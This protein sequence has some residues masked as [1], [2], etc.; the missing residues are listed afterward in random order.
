MAKLSIDKT[1][2]TV[3][4]GDTLFE[5]ARNYGGGKTYQQ[6]A[7]INNI[8][9]P[10]L[11]YVGE[12]IRLVKSSVIYPDPI[13]TV[14]K[15]QFGL[16][17]DIDNVIFISWIWNKDDTTENY[18][19]RWDYYTDNK[20]WFIGNE[21]TTND[22]YS[23]YTIPSNA[24]QVRVRV[25]P[26]SKTYKKNRKYT[27]YWES[28]WAGWFTHTISNP[29][30]KP[31]TP[32]VKL[33]GLKLTATVSNIKEENVMI[34]FQVFKDDSL[35]TNEGK[36]YA[37][38]ETASFSCNVTAGSRYKVHCRSCKDGLYSDWSDYSSNLETIPSTPSGFTKCEPKT[39]SSIQLE[40][41]AISNASGYEI[42]YTTDK[43]NFE[44]SDK[45]TSVNIEKGDITSYNITVD[46]GQEYFFRIRAVNSQG[47]SGWSEIKSTIIGSLPAAPTTWS[48]TTTVV[49]GEPLTLYWVHNSKDGS[50]QTYAHLE[51]YVDGVLKID[52]DIKNT[53][54]TEEKDKTSFYE[55]KMVDDNGNPIY[56]EGSK[57][58]WRVKTAGINNA[59]GEYSIK[60]IVN[61]Y[62]PPTLELSVTNLE[63]NTFE[64]LESFPINISALAGPKTQCPIGYV[65]SVISNEIYETV[66]N[67]GNSIIINSG[68]QIYSKHF[69]ISE[70]L[71]IELS[72]GDLNL[73]NGVSYTIRCL[74]SMDSGLTAESSKDFN[75]SW[76][77]LGYEPNAEITIDDDTLSAYIKPY[78]STHSSINYKV[79]RS[80]SNYYKTEETI[81]FVY[82]TIVSEVRTT[83][84]EQVYYGTTADGDTVYYCVIN[85]SRNIEDITL[86]VYRREF[87]GNFTELS[88]GLDGSTNT[89]IT[90][91]H[92]S[93]DYARYRIVAK[94]KANGAISYY[95]VPGYP[96]ECK[97]AIIQWD[98]D[99]T[100]FD[101]LGSE[102][103]LDQPV[104]SGSM[105]KLPYNIDI[106]DKHDSDVSLIEYIGRKHPVSYYGTHL[107][108][109]ST[110]SMEIPKDDKETLYALRRLALW[111]GDVYVREP[112]G[113][114]YWANVSVSFSQKHCELTIPIT[115][116]ITRVEGGI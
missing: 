10:D 73:E 57:L 25:R 83:T 114:G 2:V 54:T 48:S 60:R 90:D 42:E 113:S 6:L 15:K 50:S 5:I 79:T 40:W 32:I 33:E 63:G 92:P 84:G 35:S 11:I 4:R 62:A 53:N 111:M 12:K 9:N 65:L 43:S 44:E 91:P 3:E 101:I 110:W 30:S 87:D 68:D 28:S 104:W 29:P 18:Q 76:V 66:D 17:S 22:K 49:L 98:E 19:V 96:V 8:P 106:S 81:D 37:K 46:Q 89:T 94:S 67:V 72:A 27:T 56:S 1:Y 112:S 61:I 21:S 108:E 80:Y 74:V 109:S 70:K 47:N 34:Q 116:D 51:I 14:S 55:V 64:T 78:C 38:T 36:V 7:A 75:V 82:G 102:D 20:E 69:D 23:T 58:E 52:T 13:I 115:M 26:I 85:E 105:L 88:T 45:V 93:L 59:Y 100:S 71:D 86:S 97:S 39:E 41:S 107:G 103:A 77:E 16:R 24:K 31:R 99:W 95:D